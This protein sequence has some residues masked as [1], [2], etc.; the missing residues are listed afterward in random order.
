MAFTNTDDG[1][2]QIAFIDYVVFPLWDS[3]SRLINPDQSIME[4][5]AENRTYVISVRD[6]EHGT[7]NARWNDPHFNNAA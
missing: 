7:N 4:N 3:L 6:S 5:L 1:C 2:L